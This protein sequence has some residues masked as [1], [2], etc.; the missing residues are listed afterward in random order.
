MVRRLSGR[1]R[2]WVGRRSPLGAARAAT[3]CAAPAPTAA[4]AGGGAYRGGGMGALG[5]LGGIGGVI[6]SGGWGAD[7]GKPWGMQRSTGPSS[8]LPSLNTQSAP[9]SILVTRLGP[10]NVPFVLPTSSKI[11]PCPSTRSAPC[12]H[13]TRESSTT[14]SEAGSRPTPVRPGLP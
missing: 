5:A 8:A 6:A 13:D 4:P 9:I 1:R 2:R 11:Q 14:L 7:W 10:R 12:C 3:A